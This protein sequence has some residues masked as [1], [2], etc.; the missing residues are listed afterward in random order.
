MLDFKHNM[1][2][3]LFSYYKG[4][5]VYFIYTTHEFTLPLSDDQF[6]VI[7]GNLLYFV[8]IYK[9][10]LVLISIKTYILIIKLHFFP[11]LFNYF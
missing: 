4:N 1:Y 11:D 2:F 5:T 7:D 10:N 6:A 8:S 3:D 9:T